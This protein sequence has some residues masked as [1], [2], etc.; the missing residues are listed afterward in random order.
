MKVDLVMWTKNGEATLSQV[1]RRINQVVPAECVNKK[2]VVDDHSEDRTRDIARL[3][4]WQV[5]FNLGKGISDGANTAL[6]HV[7]T[8]FFC[9]FEQDLLLSPCWWIKIQDSLAEENVGAVSGVRFSDK[10]A[11]VTHLQYY[12]YKKYLGEAKLASYLHNRKFSSFSLGKTLDN[13]LWSTKAL[14]SV[15]GFPD[16]KCNAGIDTVLAYKLHVAGL[17]WIVDYTVKSVHL[18]VGGLRQELK[19]QYWYA[20]T[21]PDTWR[22]LAKFGLPP[23]IRRWGVYYRFLISFFTG[24]FIALKMRDPKIVVVHPMI[25]FYYMRGLLHG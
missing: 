9:S 23:P 11:C 22:L 17:K 19:H 3:Y 4:G 21:L 15:G 7:E 1:L 10:P 13:T 2:I 6:K 25:K 8:E 14:R 18:R 12:A 5:V 20:S 24:V 16:L